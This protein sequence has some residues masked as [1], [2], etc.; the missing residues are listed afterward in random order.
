M[1]KCIYCGSSV[2]DNENTC[3]NCGGKLVDEREY[4][5]SNPPVKEE[6]GHEPLDPDQ[7]LAQKNKRFSTI[8]TLVFMIIF[9]G[10]FLAITLSAIFAW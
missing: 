2:S 8:F 4:K 1:K 3:P 6:N 5:A 9:V 10:A 7:Q